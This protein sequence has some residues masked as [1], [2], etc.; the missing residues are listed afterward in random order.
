VSSALEHL[1]RLEQVLD[2]QSEP[3]A[4]AALFHVV[5][6]APKEIQA[7][8]PGELAL[9]LD[10]NVVLR[11]AERSRTDVVDYLGTRH[12]GPLILPGQVVQEFWNNMFPVIE[13]QAESIRRKH[14][15]LLDEIKKLDDDSSGFGD[16][17]DDVM[18][19]FGSDYAF[20]LDPT[21]GARLKLVLE[22]LQSH[23]TVPFVPRARFYPIAEARDRTKT[24]PGF[25]DPGQHGDFYVWADFL[26]GLQQAQQDENSYRRAVLVTA[27]QKLDWSRGGRAHPLLVAEVR[28]LLNVPFEIWSPQQLSEYVSKSIAAEARPEENAQPPAAL[29]S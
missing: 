29:P 25:R 18:K 3:Q 19:Q 28:A 11:L 23:A 27:D 20:A 14:Q 5:T 13:S 2:R 8:E 15:S 4:L 6:T 1:D 7:G 17:F 21:T 10:A 9:G 12:H 26:F 22:T 24:P 16:R